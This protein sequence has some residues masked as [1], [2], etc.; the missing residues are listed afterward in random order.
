MS[1]IGTMIR[2]RRY[3]AG[4][5]MTEFALVATVFLMTMFGIFMMGQ[6]VFDYNS[7]SSA[8]REAARSALVHGSTAAS[9]SAI[10]TVA[11]NAAPGL[12]LTTSDVTVTFPADLNV[13]SLLDAKIVINYP[14]TIQVPFTSSRSLTLTATAQMPVSQ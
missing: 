4:Q 14:Y 11:I 6:L 5:S 12:G 1:R 7:I 10:Q 9:E 3:G 2:Q 8:A 13:P